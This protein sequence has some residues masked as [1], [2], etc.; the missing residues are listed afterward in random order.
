[1]YE[2]AFLLQTLL[3]VRNE[4]MDRKQAI[5]KGFYRKYEQENR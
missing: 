3:D 1:M 5:C 2:P 4:K